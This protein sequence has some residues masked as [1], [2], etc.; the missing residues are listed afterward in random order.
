[1]TDEASPDTAASRPAVTFHT[2]PRIG[3]A[4]DLGA[5]DDR[6]EVEAARSQ[7][8]DIGVYKVDHGRGRCR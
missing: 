3:Y 2:L 8:R 1:M 5:A 7:E 6:G 4:H